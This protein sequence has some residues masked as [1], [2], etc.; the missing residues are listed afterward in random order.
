MMKKSAITQMKPVHPKKNMVLATPNFGLDSMRGVQYVV[1]S[2]DRAFARAPIFAVLA[3]R[4]TV[5]H[6]ARNTNP[7]GPAEEA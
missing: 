6:S 3:R 1:M 7:S 2:P 5:E 4:R